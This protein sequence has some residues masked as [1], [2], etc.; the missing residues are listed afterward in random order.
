MQINTTLDALDA[1]RLECL[2]PGPDPLKKPAPTLDEAL[3][4]VRAL[5]DVTQVTSSTNA[6]I[7]ARDLLARVPK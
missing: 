4:M 3:Q 5:L 7:A 6:V 2:K 1:I